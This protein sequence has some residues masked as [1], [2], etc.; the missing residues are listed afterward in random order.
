MTNEQA[1]DLVVTNPDLI[2]VVDN[3]LS[4]K[5]LDQINNINWKDRPWIN[6]WSHG[7]NPNS[8]G[9]GYSNPS[10]IPLAVECYKHATDFLKSLDTNLTLIWHVGSYWTIQD[11]QLNSG[12][13]IHRDTYQM[14]GVWTVLFH[15]YGNSGSTEFYKDFKSNTPYRTIDFVPGRMIAYPALY[16]HRAGQPTPG[17]TRVCHNARIQI[18]SH[19]NDQILS[20]TPDLSEQFNLNTGHC[21]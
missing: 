10:D 3:V 14:T 17:T 13:V 9:S 5:E 21:K 20:N 11:T 12:D 6:G 19:I 18:R 4:E 8:V 7:P 1:L 16:A 2:Y 15:F